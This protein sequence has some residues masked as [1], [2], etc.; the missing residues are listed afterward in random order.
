MGAACGILNTGGNVG[1]IGP[2][3][4]PLIAAH[5]GWTWGLYFTSMVLMVAVVTWFFIDPA[6]GVAR[7]A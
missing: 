4:V 3:V 2:Y 5:F 6:K 1:G 7:L